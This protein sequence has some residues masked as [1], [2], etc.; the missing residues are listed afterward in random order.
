MLV[1]YCNIAYIQVIVRKI[2]V[3]FL[4][5]HFFIVYGVQW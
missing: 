3:L 2:I 4:E 1:G 5:E